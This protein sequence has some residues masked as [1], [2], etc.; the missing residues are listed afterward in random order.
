MSNL[1]AQLPPPGGPPVVGVP[2]ES[3][4]GTVSPPPGVSAYNAAVGADGIGIILF[5]S[6]LIRIATIV[7]GIW[8]LFNFVTA[9]YD[10][11][12]AGDSK[13]SQ[14]VKEKLTASV[15]GLV[16]IV[17]SYVV[18]AIFG[19]ILFGDAGFFLNPQICGP[20]ETC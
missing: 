12:T 14:K 13:A 20:G 9:G 3:V 11:I 18:I 7:A 4:L 10:Y 17:A 19:L 2:G 15:I 16:I 5:M 8:V 1:L 6:T